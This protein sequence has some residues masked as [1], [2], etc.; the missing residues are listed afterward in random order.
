M[1]LYGLHSKT[2]LICQKQRKIGRLKSNH[3][4]MQKDMLVVM[5]EPLICI[6]IEILWLI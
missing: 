2:E 6:E 4:V 1:R 3:V 5:L